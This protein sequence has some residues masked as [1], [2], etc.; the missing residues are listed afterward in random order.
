M[1]REKEREQVPT[2][3]ALSALQDILLA[4]LSQLVSSLVLYAVCFVR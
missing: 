2:Q 4:A 1:E 3:R